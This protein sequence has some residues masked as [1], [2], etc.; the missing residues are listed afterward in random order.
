MSNQPMFAATV[1]SD[2]NE[3]LL[4]CGR[5]LVSTKSLPEDEKNPG[6]PSR[7]RITKF[8]L[9]LL[10]GALDK[11]TKG[12]IGGSLEGGNNGKKE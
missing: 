12:D 7:Y 10:V 1:S 5:F 2:L 11:R 6:Y 9:E 8:A 3:R 4:E